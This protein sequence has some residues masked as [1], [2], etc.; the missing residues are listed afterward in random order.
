MGRGVRACVRAH[1][2]VCVWGG[3]GSSYSSTTPRLRRHCVARVA[4]ACAR[5]DMHA[6]KRVRC[7]RRRAG[8]T[9]TCVATWQRM[10]WLLSS[11]HCRRGSVGSQRRSAPPGSCPTASARRVRLAGPAVGGWG[12][13]P[14]R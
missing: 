2:Y 9:L 14:V 1:A 8:V 12:W 4:H 3:A 5:P 13:P 10:G 11:I 7:T 6:L